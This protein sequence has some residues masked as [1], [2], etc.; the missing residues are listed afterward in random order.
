MRTRHGFQAKC[1][2][3]MFEDVTL[4]GT[5]LASGLRLSSYILQQVVLCNYVICSKDAKSVGEKN[6]ALSRRN[7]A[8]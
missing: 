4:P 3:V 6:F 5:F 8:R 7:L 2:D 1:P